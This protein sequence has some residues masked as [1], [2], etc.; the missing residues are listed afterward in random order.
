MD[1]QEE[2][3]KVQDGRP[4]VCIKLPGISI[5][6]PWALVPLAILLALVVAAVYLMIKNT[7]PGLWASAGMWVLFI[8]YWSAA[9]KNA[10]PTASSESPASRQLHQLLMYGALLLAF[11]PLPGLRGR[12]L[13]MASGIEVPIGLTVQA[14]AALLAVWP[15][16]TSDEIGAGPSPRKS[17]TD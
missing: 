15:G 10:A 1:R 2:G 12:W 14:G 4:A 13:P 3:K 11:L 9:A 16:G 17:A 8:A 7:G 6:G 5:T